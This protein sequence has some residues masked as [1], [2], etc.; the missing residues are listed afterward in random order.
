MAH[1]DTIT[2][3]ND[4]MREFVE[5]P[6]S[7]G[8]FLSVVVIQHG[9]GVDG[10]IQTVVLCL[11]DQGYIAAA[12]DL[13]HRQKDITLAELSSLPPTERRAKMG[14]TKD[15]EVTADVN[16]T[17]R[18]LESLRA[19]RVTSMGITGFCMG[20]RVVLSHG[21]PKPRAESGRRLLSRWHHDAAVG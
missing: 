7:A 14:E 9:N 1:W 19:P 5:T 17:V 6:Q 10:F 20:G 16:A 18:Y 12:P 11:T 2:V 15:T 13:Y 8:A 3:D 4:P 21:L